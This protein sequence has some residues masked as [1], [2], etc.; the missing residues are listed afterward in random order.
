MIIDVHTHYPD[1]K[2]ILKSDY[3]TELLLKSR[4]REGVDKRLLTPQKVMPI[5]VDTFIDEWHTAGIDKMVI[6]AWPLMDR[7]WGC[8]VP[9]S[10]VA[11]IANKYPDIVI[12]FAGVE[13]VDT[14][15]RLNK[16][17]LDDFVKS[18]KDLGL[19]GLKF[20][21]IYSHYRPDDKR[22][23]LVFEKC[24][25][26][27]IPI[28]IHSSAG[29]TQKNTPFSYAN[30]LLLDDAF[31]D[32]PDLRVCIAHLGDPW[33]GEVYN[34]I[35]KNDN[36]YTDVSANCM[37]PMWLAWN[38]VVAKEYR[39][40]DKVLFGSDGPGVCRPVSK[41]IEYFKTGLN[42][43]AKNAGWPTFTAEEINGI[44]GKNAKKWLK[45]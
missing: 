1:Q 39:V 10:V 16:K 40:L 28:M 19:K 30:P 45:L 6:L 13:A 9:D 32:F 18:I 26:L 37:R 2:Y 43:I 12:G 11:D 15:D 31:E 21:P 3:A 4:A 7:I 42:Q 20:T 14:H 27:D 33:V 5:D 8:R 17:G 25:E 24:V 41:F 34:L 38:L 44:L 29:H 22:N 35:V 36:V 23:Y